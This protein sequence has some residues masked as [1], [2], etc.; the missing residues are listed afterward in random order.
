MQQHRR[1]PTVLSIAG[2]DSSGGAGI[3]ADIKAISATGSYAA[4][5]ITA[6]TAQNTMGVQAIEGIAQ[7]FIAQQLETVFSDLN[8]RAVKIGMLHRADIIDTVKAA[9]LKYTPPFVVLDPV[10][11]SK[12]GTPLLEDALIDLLK[13]NLFPN[14]TLITPNILETEK[15]IGQR[16]HTKEE[17]AEAAQ[18]IS[19]TY[20]LN[21]LIKGGHLQTTTSC[22]ILCQSGNL[23]YFELPRIHTQHTHGTGCTLSAAIAS[24][25]AQGHQ[26][27]QAISHAKHYL[28]QAIL[29]GSHQNVGHGQGPVDHFYFIESNHAFSD[30]LKINSAEI[31]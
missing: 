27:P 23:T 5:V 24:Y 17:M 13:T 4:S 10:M 21:V 30:T 14:A 3:Q 11:V 6:L 9:L 16:I 22:D 2:S 31:L 25:L 7:P 20:Q 8:I 19:Q 28:Y 12:N 1:P 18:F 15:I 29:S 26:L